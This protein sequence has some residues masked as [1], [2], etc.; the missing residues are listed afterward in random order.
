MT[1][2]RGDR[3]SSSTRCATPGSEGP[4]LDSRLNLLDDPAV[5]LACRSAP[6]I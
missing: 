4:L 1:L 5:Q 3:D 6:P 2:V